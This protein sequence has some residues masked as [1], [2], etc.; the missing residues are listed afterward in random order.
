MINNGK[1]FE[2]CFKDSIP[3]DNSMF[4]LRLKDGTASFN[5]GI[6]D[7]VRFQ[8]SNPC[9]FILFNGNFLFMLELKSH[10]GSSIPLSCFR[11]NQIDELSKYQYN[12]KVLPYFLVYFPDKR[13]CFA[14][15]ISRYLE[16]ISSSDRK[17]IPLSFFEHLATNIPIQ[18][19][20]TNFI[21][22]TGFFRYMGF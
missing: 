22:D 20:N 8:S 21:L 7:N 4:L 9:D 19:K 12:Y 11:K 14:L 3:K 2:K 5:K 15:H 16:F 10:N 18:Y 13:K 6:S 1:R 17:S